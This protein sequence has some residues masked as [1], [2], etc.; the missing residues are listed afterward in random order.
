MNIFFFIFFSARLERNFQIKRVKNLT[1]CYQL[2]RATQGTVNKCVFKNQNVFPYN[3]T[4]ISTSG[5]TT[6]S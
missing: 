3:N 5:I 1:N 4:I 6:L 2:L